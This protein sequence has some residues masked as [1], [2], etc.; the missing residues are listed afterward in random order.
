MGLLEWLNTQIDY[1][2]ESGMDV[3][4]GLETLKLFNEKADKLESLSFTYGLADN[5]VT[6]SAKIGQAVE[7]HRQGPDEESTD[8]FVLTMRFFV[9]DNESISLRNMAKL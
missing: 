3:D 9:Q 5:G 1:E 8:A 4:A 6:I 2:A 7:S